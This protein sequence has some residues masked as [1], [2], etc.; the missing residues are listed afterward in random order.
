MRLFILVIVFAFAVLVSA[1]DSLKVGDKISAGTITLVNG[2]KISF[3]NLEFDYDDKITFTNAQSLETEFLY[4]SSIKSIE[5]ENNSTYNSAQLNEMEIV[6]K[7][8][9]QPKEKTFTT[10]QY[11]NKSIE[12]ENPA[13]GKS[14]VYFVRTNGTGALINFRHFDYDK[15]I[16]KF[17]GRGYI[18]YE[19]EPGE[20]TFWVGASN[21]SYVTANLEA[22]K[23]YVIETIPV[24]GIAYAKVNIEIPNRLSS[25]KYL[26]Q[27]K[28]IFA[29]LSNKD[30]NKT[31]PKSELQ[32]Q[33]DY[34]TEIK[35]G[36]EV[37]RKRVEKEQDH[38]L[39]ANQYFE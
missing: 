2:K 21:S 10:I 27:K 29:I 9:S 11:K 26:K 16:G 31:P 34:Q 25:K 6:S 35:R 20:H 39:P 23:I 12:L 19:C 18:R 17:A 8:S 7:K 24:M 1:Q 38:L 4:K 13:E 28:R 30:F 3:Y 37:Y 32:S 14:V 15:F 5:T 33:S 22:G 36:L